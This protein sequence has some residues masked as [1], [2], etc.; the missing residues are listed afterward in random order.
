M[1][2]AGVDVAGVDVAGVDVAGDGVAG[3]RAMAIRGEE[4]KKREWT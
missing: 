4:R 1:C 3:G 2:V